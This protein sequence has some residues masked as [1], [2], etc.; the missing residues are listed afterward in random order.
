[1]RKYHRSVIWFFFKSTIAPFCSN[2]SISRTLIH[3]H[4]ICICTATRLHD[5]QT[6]QASAP[7]CW[8]IATALSHRGRR[9][10]PPR[11]TQ[12]P[13]VL[14]R[15]PASDTHGGCTHQAA[16]R[17]RGTPGAAPALLLWRIPGEARTERKG[18]FFTMQLKC[19]VVSDACLVDSGGQSVCTHTG[20][21]HHSQR[22]VNFLIVLEWARLST[23]AGAGLFHI[24]DHRSVQTFSF[25]FARFWHATI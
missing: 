21:S 18:R 19:H 17:A 16:L 11:I 13:F 2:I 5:P 14:G 4:Q 23:G 9:V 6:Q 10:T 15:C 8:I 25:D 1:M 7:S 24:M 12:R 22:A 20:W 3:N